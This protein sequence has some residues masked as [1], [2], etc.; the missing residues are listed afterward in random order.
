MMKAKIHIK[1]T[2]GKATEIE[3][4]TDDLMFALT[5]GRAMLR[6]AYGSAY[7]L[8]QVKQ[9]IIKPMPTEQKP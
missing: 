3:V 7:F 9:L 2:D 1:F 5:N 4:D 6:T 8:D